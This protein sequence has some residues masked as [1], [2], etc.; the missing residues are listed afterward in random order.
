[1]KER[2]DPIDLQRLL[3]LSVHPCTG[4]SSATPN[5]PPRRRVGRSPESTLC[6]HMPDWAVNKADAVLESGKLLK[7]GSQ[8]FFLDCGR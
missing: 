7:R 6:R 2:T 3:G 1:M 4:W 8:A 5:L